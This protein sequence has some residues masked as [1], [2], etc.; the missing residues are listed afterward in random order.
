[1]LPMLV[2]RLLRKK[3]IMIMAG[4]A[5]EGTKRIYR[6]MLFGLGGYIISRVTRLFEKLNYALTDVIGVSIESPDSM[7]HYL[8]LD[9]YKNKIMC[10]PYYFIDS[11]RFRVTKDLAERENIVGFVGRLSPEKGVIE[12]AKSVPLVLSKKENVR[13]LI[14]GDGPLMVDMENE[15][16][17]RGCL[18]KVDF[19]GWIPN[20][21]IPDYLNRMKVH[22]IPSYTEAFSGTSIEAMAC[23]TI[24]IG[25]SVG[26]IPDIIKDNKTGFLLRDNQ[27]Q[28]IADKIIKVLNSPELEKIQKNALE[29]IEETLSF[30][31]VVERGEQALSILTRKQ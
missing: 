23:G 7:T 28:T 26:G 8:K 25:N 9:K 10:L 6:T 4:A 30:E 1:M 5:G 24:V 31:K 21:R 14:V 3:T 20:E 22:I 12:L 2:A 19:V 13:F 27:P 15:L 18:D 16:R 11:S 29:F 17:E